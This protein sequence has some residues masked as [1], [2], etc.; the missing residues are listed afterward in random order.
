MYGLVSEALTELNLIS[1]ELGQ[2]A[3]SSS[4][5]SEILQWIT[6]TLQFSSKIN[7][8]ISLGFLACTCLFGLSFFFIV[9]PMAKFI[10]QRTP[11]GKPVN[12]IYIVMILLGVL[13]MA[14]LSDAIGLHFVMGPIFFWFGN[15]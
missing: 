8:V 10:I 12:E 13:V 6:I 7:F 2:I 1:T 3:L 14:G 9:R 11:V 4:M 15:A 5:I